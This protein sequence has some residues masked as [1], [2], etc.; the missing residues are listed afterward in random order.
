MQEY[1]EFLVRNRQDFKQA[2]ELCARAYQ[3]Y[4]EKSA[5]VHNWAL[6][7]MKY[8]KQYDEAEKLFEKALELDAEHAPLLHVRN[9]CWFLKH[10]R[11]NLKKVDELERKFLSK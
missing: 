2:E 3:M 1:S 7:Q 10:I 6:F 9:Y 5:C 11:G 8:N 4:P